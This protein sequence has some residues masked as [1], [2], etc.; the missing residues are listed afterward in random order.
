LLFFR[1]SANPAFLIYILSSGQPRILNRELG[2]KVPVFSAFM[3]NGECW[4][5][6]LFVRNNE[7]TRRVS[8][9]R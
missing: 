6:V 3:A 5:A 7:N 2:N 9:V 8:T 1:F 4:A